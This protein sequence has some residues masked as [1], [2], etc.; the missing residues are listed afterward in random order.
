LRVKFITSHSPTKNVAT[1]LR[2]GAGATWLMEDSGKLGP[3]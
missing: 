1:G 3:L 2:R